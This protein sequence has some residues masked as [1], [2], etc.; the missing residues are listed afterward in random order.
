[1][2]R[3]QG[4]LPSAGTVCFYEETHCLP[5]LPRMECRGARPRGGNQPGRQRVLR[6]KPKQGRRAGR[7][8]IRR[9]PGD[10][11][12]THPGHGARRPAVR[13][14]GLHRVQRRR[15]GLS[16]DDLPDRPDQRPP[17]PVVSDHVLGEGR[18]H[19]GRGGR[20]GPDGHAPVG[21]CRAG[22]G[23]LAGSAVG[24]VRVSVPRPGRSGRQR[25]PAAILVQGHG[26]VVAGRRGAGRIGRRPAMVP[27]NLHRR[28]E[29]LRAEQQ[30]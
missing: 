16:R 28:R 14:A 15:A 23:V 24:A 3:N 17:G 27:P 12:T 26:D 20:G 30:L 5:G 4:Q 9:E 18:G 19:Q 2:G 6:A 11:T 7:V 25:Q 29:E 13:E 21:E 1:M 10:P 22:R 8:V